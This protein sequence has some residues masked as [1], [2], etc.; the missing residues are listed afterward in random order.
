VSLTGIV[1]LLYL[2][3]KRLSGLLVV[4]LGLLLTYVV[5]KIWVN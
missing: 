4:A 5:Y 1:L 2:K 3:K